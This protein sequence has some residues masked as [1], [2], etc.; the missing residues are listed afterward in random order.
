MHCE[1]CVYEPIARCFREVLLPC[2]LKVFN[3]KLRCFVES[4]MVL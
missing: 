2:Q 4:E 3:E 1:H